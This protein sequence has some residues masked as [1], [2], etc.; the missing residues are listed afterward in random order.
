MDPSDPISDEEEPEIEISPEPSKF[1]AKSQKYPNLKT[2]PAVWAFLKQ[3]KKQ[4][5]D[6]EFPSCT[7]DNLS[8]AQQVAL[9]NIM[10]NGDIIVKPSDKGGNVVVMDKTQYITMCLKILNNQ[11]WYQ[12]VPYEKLIEARSQYLCILDQAYQQC[13]IQY[14]SH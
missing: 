4:I 8:Q 2:C 6:L 13:L 12:R 5:E 9:T 10:H 11:E 14:S 7:E 3:T 1:K